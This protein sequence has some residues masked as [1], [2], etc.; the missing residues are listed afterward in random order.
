MR[1]TKVN[2]SESIQ[3]KLSSVDEAF[4]AI[5]ADIADFDSFLFI[6]I[7]SYHNDIKDS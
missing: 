2:K 7:V 6:E 4:L 5:S 3:T 1:F